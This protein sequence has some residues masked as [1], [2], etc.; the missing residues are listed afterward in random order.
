MYVEGRCFAYSQGI[1]YLPMLEILR[2]L[3]AC[4]G[5]KRGWSQEP[6]PMSSLNG[7]TIR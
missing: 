2:Q 3:T 1:P 5:L 7:S 6:M 4:F